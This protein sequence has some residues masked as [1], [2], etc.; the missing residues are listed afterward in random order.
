ML[1]TRRQPFETFNGL[2]VDEMLKRLKREPATTDSTPL[3]VVPLQRSAQPPM[4]ANDA[5][6]LDPSLL[7]RPNPQ[8]GITLPPESPRQTAPDVS[9][10]ALGNR[11]SRGIQQ[12]LGNEPKYQMP[13]VVPPARTSPQDLIDAGAASR[14]TPN[15]VRL[16]PN[17]ELGDRPVRVDT[18]N[19]LQDEIAYRNQLEAYKPKSHNSRI[20][21]I[22]LG[23]LRG[24][25]GGLGGAI[26]GALQGGFDP[27]SDEKYAREQ[28]LARS[29]QNVAR[30]IAIQGEQAKLG[31]MQTED[32]LRRAQTVELQ[33][34]PDVE[35]RKAESDALKLAQTR[36]LRNLALRRG[37]KLDPHNPVDAALLQDAADARVHVDPDAWNNSSSNETTVEMLNPDNPTQTQRVVLNKVTGTQTVL[38]PSGYVQ[39]VNRE[40]GMTPA[41]TTNAE[42]QREGLGLRREGVD[43][44]RRGLDLREGELNVEDQR[45]QAEAESVNSNIDRQVGELRREAA[46]EEANAANPNI[47]PY[48]REQARKR[49]VTLRDRIGQIER[50]K[51]APVV[52]RV[53]GSSQTSAPSRSGKSLQRLD[54]SSMDNQVKSH[55]DKGGKAIKVR[56][57]K[58][59]KETLVDNYNDYLVAIGRK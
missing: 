17:V 2:T 38:G 6:A 23:A 56:D 45:K 26:V 12:T 54:S 57:M 31:S 15:L 32:A 20:A 29:D 11:I 48:A 22:A 27:A 25:R 8:F 59:G 7:V 16:Q 13:E 21:S 34:K 47:D 40:T 41:Q 9:M 28:N 43:L 14:I 49:A 24:L 3:P 42:I 53:Q 19:P 55:F 50:Q 51:K 35:A 10:E 36:V 46:G 1:L 39:P 30:Q 52:P 58:T 33:R 18:G 4:V 44:Q 37:Q 5:P